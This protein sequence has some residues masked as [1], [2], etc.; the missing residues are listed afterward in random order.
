MIYKTK[1]LPSQNNM[2]P[3]HLNLGGPDSHTG[4]HSLED[5]TIVNAIKGGPI[6]VDREPS[7]LAKINR[8][9]ELPNGNHS[10]NNDIHASSGSLERN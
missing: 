7:C 6:K 5:A 10:H 9:G 1:D 2:T 3:R 4:K 8:K